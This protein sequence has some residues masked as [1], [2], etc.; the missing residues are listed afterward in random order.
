M[1][2]DNRDLE[3]EIGPQTWKEGEEGGK[4]RYLEEMWGSGRV[5]ERK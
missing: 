4:K 1:A 3:I 5:L 2:V